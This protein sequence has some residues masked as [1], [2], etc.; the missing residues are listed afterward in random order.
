MSAKNNKEQQEHI[1]ESVQLSIFDVFLEQLQNDGVNVSSSEMTDVISKLMCARE[2]IRKKEYEERKRK[3]KIEKEKR[4]KEE[5]ERREAH[6]REVTSMDLPLD[7]ENVF[8]ADIRTQGIHTESIP[9]ALILSL[10]NLAKVDIEYISAITG[11]DYKT[12]I[13][14]LKGSIY[15]NPETWDECFYKGW[16]TTEEYLDEGMDDVASTAN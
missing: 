5:K 12:V 10:S 13:S 6:I 7:W 15:Q 9:D 14:T 8:N 4:K 1:I 2:E 11:E 3:E 16:E